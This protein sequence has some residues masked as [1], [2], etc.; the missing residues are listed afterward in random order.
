MPVIEVSYLE[1]LLIKIVKGPLFKLLVGLVLGIISFL[2]DKIYIDAM[3]AILL[4]IIFDFITGIAA[5]KKNGHPIL[6]TKVFRTCKKIVVY[7]LLISAGYLAETATQRIL[8]ILDETVMAFLGVTELISILE[9]VGKMGYAIPQ[10]LLNQ[11]NKFK[12]EK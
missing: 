7:F 12:D 4:L 8:P 2:Y 3:V 10:K 1:T 6:S 9:N 11:L 5:Q